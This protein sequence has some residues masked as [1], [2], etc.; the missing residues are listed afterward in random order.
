MNQ[1]TWISAGSPAGQT[2][3]P[4]CF[5]RNPKFGVC[6][7]NEQNWR[8]VSRGPGAPV[9]RMN[10][11][12]SAQ[13]LVKVMS[14]VRQRGWFWTSQWDAQR[15]Q[16][17][18]AE[19]ERLRLMRELKLGL[20]RAQEASKNRNC[21]RDVSTYIQLTAALIYAKGWM[22]DSPHFTTKCNRPLL[23]DEWK[24]KLTMTGSME[25]CSCV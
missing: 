22:R 24:E 9:N 19:G 12:C 17:L 4:G 1:L 2:L 14:G 23:V 6:F 8:P 18:P 16:P 15:D 13:P 25:R 10:G 5:V 11:D 20:L 7:N 21:C 3:T